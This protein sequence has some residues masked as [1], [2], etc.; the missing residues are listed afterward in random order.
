MAVA[1]P[2]EGVVIVPD[3]TG[4]VNAPLTVSSP[5]RYTATVVP[6]PRRL[7]S[8]RFPSTTIQLR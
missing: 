2:S 5:R 7:P 4:R 3:A 6:A 1:F 8:G